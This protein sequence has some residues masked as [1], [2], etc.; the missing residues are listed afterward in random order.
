MQFLGQRGERGVA[1]GLDLLPQPLQQVG[2]PLRE[3]DDAR[4]QALRMQ[5]QAQHVQRWLQQRRGQ[6]LEQQ[7]HHAV[8]RDQ[9]PVPVDQQG[10]KGLVAPEHQLERLPGAGQGRVVE[11]VLAEHRRIAGGGEHAVALAQ[12]H[13]QAV[14]QAQ[15]HLAA[16]QGA[17]GLDAAQVAGGDVGVTGEV[18]L[19]EAPALAPVAQHGAYRGHGA[20]GQG[21]GR[22]HGG[23]DSPAASRRP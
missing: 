17:A 4:R 11:A 12:R 22:A 13:L 15:H 6:A 3:V 10:R 8:G 23:H 1:A 7:R 19:A 20:A 9:R 21:Q 2:A 16:G 5:A 14:G 18:E